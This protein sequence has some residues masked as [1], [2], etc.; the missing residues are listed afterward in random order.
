[1]KKIKSKFIASFLLIAMIMAAFVGG[2]SVYSQVQLVDN[3]I[4]DYRETL[5]QEYDAMMK[6]QVETATS[7]VQNVY[8]EQQ[9]GLLTEEQAKVKAANLVRDLRF[10]GSNYFWI[11]TTEG[12]NVVLLGRDTEGKSRLA[13]KDPNGVEYVKEFIKNGQQEGGG[14]SDYQFAKPNETQPLPKRG[15]TLLFKPYNWVI[16]TGDWVDNIEKS[17]SEKQATYQADMRKQV[18]INVGIIL[19][20]LVAVIAFA[21]YFS[22]KISRPIIEVAE[23]SK[24]V[25]NG[26]FTREKLNVSSK[27]E[28]GDLAD[29]FNKMSDSLRE[30]VQRV[31]QASS[32]VAATSQELTAGAEQSAQAS[33]EVAVSVTEM[34]QGAEKQKTTV[35]EVAAVAE[36]L[37]A[38]AEQ[39]QAN[40]GNVVSFAE[41]TAQSADEGRTAITTTIEQMKQIQSVVNRS[42]EI[43]LQLGERSQDIG[44]IVDTIS[45]IADQTNLLA[46]NAA[47]EAARAGEQGRGFAVVADEVRKLAE[48]SQEAAKEIAHLIASMQQDTEKAV[49]AMN[50]G[51]SVVETGSK[52][53]AQAGEAFEEIAQ[54]IE[55]VVAQVKG[56]SEEMEQMTQGNERIASS[57]RDLDQI[58]RVIADQT[59]NVSA[60]S[61]EQA[62]SMEEIAS[63]SQLLAKMAEELD[64]SLAKYKIN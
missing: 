9:K 55:K 60:S 58:S 6:A 43:T 59:Q 46:L 37:A 8:N 30:L 35:D 18:G 29:S 34:A 23:E 32:Q 39:I 3:E 64:Q 17:V 22:R 47:I 25:A 49:S 13:S 11:D 24:A 15:Y 1:M 4:Q 63:S 31:S 27:D 50:N 62:A 45:A 52:V 7:L 54:Q 26:D 53:V 36:Q 40:T 19:V 57:V 2:Y 51:T 21:L 48:Q 33:S 28:L 5:F 41:R 10:N 42:A 20:A 61:E 38:G 16:G 12:I 44:K 14:Y 56:I